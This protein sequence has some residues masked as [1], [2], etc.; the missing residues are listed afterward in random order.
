MRDLAQCFDRESLS[1]AWTWPHCWPTIWADPVQY[2]ALGRQARYKAVFERAV[3]EIEPVEV[4]GEAGDVVWW[5]GRMLHS[6]GIHVG[7]AIR[8]AVPADFQQDR[9]TVVPPSGR[10]PSGHA[11]GGNRTYPDDTPPDV[12][13]RLARARHTVDQV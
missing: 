4:C 6:A 5:H 8:F 12:V 2:I 11:G 9:P 7:D 10:V 1:E 3:A 13:C